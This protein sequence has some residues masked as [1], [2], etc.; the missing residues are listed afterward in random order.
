MAER[1]NKRRRLSPPED[2]A[3]AVPG[4]ANHDLEADYAERLAKKKTTEKQKDKLMIKTQEGRLADNP[5]HEGGEG[6]EGDAD[7][8][9]ARGGDD[10]HGDGDSG[11]A[12]LQPKPKPKKPRLPPKEEIRL[13][14][15]DLAKVAQFISED[16]EEHVAQLG[17]LTE[18]ASH[19]NITVQKLALATQ[20]AVYKD[21]I[22][23]YRIRPLSQADLNGKVSKEVKRQRTFEQGLLN[24]YK[25]YLSTLSHLAVAKTSKRIDQQAASGLATVAISCACTLLTSLPHFN[26]RGDLMR[27][28]VK[29]LASRSFDS[30]SAKC[31]EAIEKLF[32]EDE[33]G[34]ASLDMVTQLTKMMKGK[35]YNVHESVLNTFL[36]LRLL[37]EFSHK[38]APNHIDKDKPEENVRK[39]K[40][41]KKEFRTKREKKVMRE[42]KQVEK[43]MKEA[44]AAV[45]YEERDKN[46]AETLKLVFVAYFRILKERV[47]H[48]K[49]AVL[50]GLAKYSH[51][52]NQDFFGDVLEVLKD[53]INEAEAAIEN[54]PED[55]EDDEDL[56]VDDAARRSATRESLLCII[57]AFALLQGQ[58][59]VAKQATALSLDLTFFIKHLYRTLIPLSMDLD[60]ELGGKIA[61]LSD[62]NGLH[63]PSTKENKVNV[64]TTAVLLLRSLQ[65]VLLPPTNTK[66]VP[67][68]RVAAFIKQLET[69]SLHLPQKSAIA[70]QE[71]L[72]QVTKTHS[73][74]IAALWHT[75][76]RKGDGVFDPLSQEVESSNPFASTVWEGELLRH[77]FDP[78]VRDAVKAVEG[79]VK[80][81]RG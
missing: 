30:D 25:N 11:V 24:G 53:L 71:L 61:H 41:Y 21:I 55:E 16:P 62:P 79:N 20:L 38:A 35:S 9:L 69:L 74:R 56:E 42:R 52:I 51:L 8:F 32:Q 7:S 17:M 4:F 34:H 48:L 76:E 49:G 39:P 18:L 14:K 26:N 2:G 31:R 44:D 13:A 43:E 67:P 81:S 54:D 47:P 65:S 63:V 45:S 40:A 50:E 75:E 12:D 5:R 6:A 1:A 19:E 64:S 80:T 68:V 22:P 29:K 3:R 78:K 10:G 66:S 73:G 72:K 23:G 59:D 33:E 27:I 15:E 28:L 36:H 58:L 57:T 70:V 37:S 77:H 60:I 46:Q